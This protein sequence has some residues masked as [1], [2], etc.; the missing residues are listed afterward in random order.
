MPSEPKHRL[1]SRQLLTEIA[2]GKYSP[3]GRLPS[4]AQL[5]SRFNV[6]RPTVA[7]AL[8]DLQ[9]Q[10]LVERRVG[11]GSYIRDPSSVSPGAG[12][13]Q[14]GL[15]I[16]GLGTTEIFEVICG[17]L[18]ALARVHD[19]S[20]LWGSGASPVRPQDASVEDA[21]G[22]CQQFIQARVSGVFFAPF[23]HVLKPE[24]VNRRLAERLRQA[25]VAVVLLDRDLGAFPSRSEFDL[26]GTDNFAAGYVIAD[27]L[28]KLGCR[29]LIF[30]APPHS[31]PTVGLRVAGAREAILDRR[32]PA[33][34]DF[35]RV[36]DPDDLR[37]VRG[38]GAGK[39]L[40][41]V[42]CAN[43]RVAALLMRSL[44]RTGVDVPRDVRVVGFDDVRFATLLS[45]PLTTMHQPCREVAVTAFR[46]MQDR[47]SDPGLPPRGFVVPAGLV[48][49]E[50]CG[51]Y[52]PGRLDLEE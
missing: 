20:L 44:A 29:Q 2:A 30:V 49:R 8:R 32:R 38:L 50:S 9:D 40:D 28:L 31:A 17:E 35:L 4:E 36:G 51:A 42:I 34:S 3:S 37:F 52:L 7:R 47:I 23:E 26:V 48:V 27:H 16:P 39:R 14:L 43:D 6:A 46:A 11:S 25:G 1:I 10:G 21:E 33:P 18:A 19:F 41:A 5:V 45:V 12:Q 13:R 15:L 24:E 22:L